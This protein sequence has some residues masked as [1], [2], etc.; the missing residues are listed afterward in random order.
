VKDWC[1][2][3]NLLDNVIKSV[4]Y[5][6]V[7]KRDSLPYNEQTVYVTLNADI[8]FNMAQGDSLLNA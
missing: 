3:K 7:S 8:N 1:N 4:S 5:Q 6:I 2:V